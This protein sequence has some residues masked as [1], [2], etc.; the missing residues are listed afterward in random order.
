MRCQTDLETKISTSCL[1]VGVSCIQGPAQDIDSIHPQMD[2]TIK[3]FLIGQAKGDMLSGKKSDWN[4]KNLYDI[5][6]ELSDT[7]RKYQAAGAM[8][9]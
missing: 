1:K 5:M 9:C 3:Y 4:T 7:R 2:C 6:S 8:I